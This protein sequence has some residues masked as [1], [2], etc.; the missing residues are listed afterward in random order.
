MARSSLP[1]LDLTSL[2]DHRWRAAN[3][4][5]QDLGVTA[6][7]GAGKTTVLVDRF[8]NI[9]RDPLVGP[10]GILAIT[11]KDTAAAEMKERVIARF[12][13]DGEVLLRRRTE[14]AYISTI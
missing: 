9:A 2:T 14:S 10:E 7:A 11:F 12:E 1:S 8:V 6:G 4:L 3:D 5:S 13:Q